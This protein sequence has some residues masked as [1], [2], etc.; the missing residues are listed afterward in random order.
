[1]RRSLLHSRDLHDVFR[2]LFYAQKI[3]IE[4]TRKNIATPYTGRFEQVLPH[5]IKEWFDE[6]KEDLK[7][8]REI[9][10]R[11]EGYVTTS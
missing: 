10:I 1:M 4:M 9:M 3:A 6:W 11:V 2:G 8:S 5:W 7:C